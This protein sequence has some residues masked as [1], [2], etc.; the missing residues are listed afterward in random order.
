MVAGDRDK[1]STFGCSNIHEIVV[2]EI[3]RW[4]RRKKYKKI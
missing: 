3:L 2:A 1:R 4:K